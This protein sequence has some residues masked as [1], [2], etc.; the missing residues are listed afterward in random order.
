MWLWAR[1]LLPS[2]K[3]GAMP[4]LS[5]GFLWAR[6]TSLLVTSCGFCNVALQLSRET[7]QMHANE[8]GMMFLFPII[9]KGT[10]NISTHAD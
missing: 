8:A 1:C 5:G 10:G 3:V 9:S 4:P 2:L 7:Q 6:G